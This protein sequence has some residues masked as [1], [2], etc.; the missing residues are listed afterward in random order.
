MFWVCLPLAA[1]PLTVDPRKT[2][3][4]VGGRPPRG[5]QSEDTLQL[6]PVPQRPPPVGAT[7]Q[8]PGVFRWRCWAS[9]APP[10]D[11]PVGTG[12]AL[13]G[14]GPFPCLSRVFPS[15]VTLEE[16]RTLHLLPSSPF[17][18]EQWL[19][20]SPPWQVFSFLLLIPEHQC[21]LADLSVPL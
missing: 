17:S 1:L 4:A 15:P 2:R 21:R 19:Q 20:H 16:G 8:G 3:W 10:S 5:R 7:H 9:C 13:S 11:C 12:P 18:R 6:A 14:C